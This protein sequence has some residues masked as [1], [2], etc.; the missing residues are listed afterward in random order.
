MDSQRY[1]ILIPR[2]CKCYFIWQ[3][4]CKC[5]YT[6][7]LEV[8]WEYWIIQVDPKC[9]HMYPYKKRK[10]ERFQNPLRKEKA[11]FRQSREVT[12]D[13]GPNWRD[14]VTSQGIL[15]ATRNWKQQEMGPPLQLLEGAWPWRHFGFGLVK[16]LSDFCLWN[17]QS[18]NLF[19]L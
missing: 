5:D 6:K 12:E 16:L 9:N 10:T 13:V 8:R 14:V 17:C 18:I 19:M 3:S 11:M 15:E 2:Y 7:N 1:Q 4:L